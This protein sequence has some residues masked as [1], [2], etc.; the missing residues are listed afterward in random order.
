[1]KLI[2]HCMENLKKSYLLRLH[3]RILDAVFD[4]LLIVAHSFS[5][6]SSIDR[7]CKTI[8]VIYA[9]ALNSFPAQHYNHYS[10]RSNQIT[11]KDGRKIVSEVCQNL[12]CH[13]V[14][15]QQPVVFRIYKDIKQSLV[16]TL[17]L[18][19]RAEIIWDS[20]KFSIWFKW[21]KRR[22]QRPW[23]CNKPNWARWHCDRL[24][25]TSRL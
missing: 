10:I 14:H 8:P 19:K 20:R 18:I 25:A 22:L 24:T 4:N 17:L 2:K 9:V 7:I 1:M 5:K 16:A 11:T 3:T 6:C 21:E 13:D 15:R 12:T 23:R